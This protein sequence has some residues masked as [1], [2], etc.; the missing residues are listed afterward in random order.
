VIDL[1]IWGSGDLSGDLAGDLSGDLS[2]DL[3][4]VIE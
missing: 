1:V 4:G 2:E 3:V